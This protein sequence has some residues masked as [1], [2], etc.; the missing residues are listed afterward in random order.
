MSAPRCWACARIAA[1]EIDNPQNSANRSE[2]TSYDQL[3]AA[4]HINR[5]AFGLLRPEI[6]N[7]SSSTNPPVRQRTQR[8]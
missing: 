5:S 4:R 6:P 3:A 2:E 7:R 1:S 8:R